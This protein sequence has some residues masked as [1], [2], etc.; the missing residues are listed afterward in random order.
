MYK[1][2]LVATDGSKLSGKAVT[3]AIALAQA[4][5]A[6]LTAFYA[7][8][9]YPMPAFSD[10]VV[11][12]PVS[13]KDYA[14]MALKEAEQILGAGARRRPRPAASNARRCTRSRR[15][16]GRRSSPRRRRRSATRS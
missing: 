4:L 8:P 11:Y 12:D 16:R 7:S 15:R 2:M 5:S 3:Q 10:G 13:R 1:H 6:K 14:A 9:D